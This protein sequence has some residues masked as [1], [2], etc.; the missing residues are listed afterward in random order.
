MSSDTLAVCPANAPEKTRAV[1]RV[2]LSARSRVSLAGLEVVG[3]EGIG[4]LAR[5]LAA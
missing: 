2:F 3:V 1:R 4:D 5:R